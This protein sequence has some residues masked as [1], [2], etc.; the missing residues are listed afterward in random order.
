MG[1]DHTAGQTLR[2]DVEHT[3]PE[4]QVEAS[5]NAQIG[6]AIHDSIGTCFFLG[7]AIQGKIEFL[8][9]LISAMTGKDFTI[10][11]LKEIAKGTILREKAFNKNAGLTKAHDRL[12]E[13]FYEEENPD[14]STVFDVKDEDIEKVHEFN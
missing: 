8:A 10:D 3:K 9:D 1:A 7:G 12:A 2:A 6:N 5:K 4:G 13:F 14:V 11:I